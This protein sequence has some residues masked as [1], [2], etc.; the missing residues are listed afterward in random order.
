MVV[1]PGSAPELLSNQDSVLLL[2]YGTLSVAQSVADVVL[3]YPSS[4]SG[5]CAKLVIKF[6]VCTVSSLCM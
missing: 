5:L 3:M 4:L 2:N 6:H 1:P